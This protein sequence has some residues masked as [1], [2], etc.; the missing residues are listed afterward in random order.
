MSHSK[1]VE[2]FHSWTP[3]DSMIWI[4]TPRLQDHSLA[5]LCWTSA[6]SANGREGHSGSCLSA[7]EST[8]GTQDQVSGPNWSHR[9]SGCRQRPLRPAPFEWGACTWNRALS[10]RA[11]RTRRS[12]KK[13]RHLAALRC[14]VDSISVAAHRCC[15]VLC[16]LVRVLVGTPR[17]HT[18]CFHLA[19]DVP[20]LWRSATACR[21]HA[22][23]VS[24][25]RWGGNLFT[26]H[27]C[28]TFFFSHLKLHVWKKILFY[29]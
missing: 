14:A 10:L 2:Y 23:R 15:T 12:S 28:R 27:L 7:R 29:D 24:A 9:S 25:T 4:T 5:F 3:L 26:S 18:A 21:S 20:V 22:G 13:A 1:N 8:S 16:G 6:A 19:P 17:T 11:A